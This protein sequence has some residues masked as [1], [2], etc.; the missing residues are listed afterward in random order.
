[1]NI[2]K[3]MGTGLFLATVATAFTPLA[4][5]A[6]DPE[7]EARIQAARE[8][9]DQAAADLG[10]AYAAVYAEDGVD[11]K[12]A[13]LGVLLDGEGDEN[14]VG[15][16]GV[17]PGGG[18]AA[19]G[20]TA[21]DTLI[22]I[23]DTSLLGL[24]NPGRTLGTELKA[25]APGDRVEVVY[26]RKGEEHT[27]TVETT[28]M[29][30]GAIAAMVQNMAPLVE[31]VGPAGQRRITIEH[32]APDLV[33]VQAEGDLAGYFGVGTGILV[34]HAPGSQDDLKAGDIVL[35][36]DGKAVDTVDALDRSLVESGKALELVVRRQGQEKAVTFLLGDRES[37]GTLRFQVMR[38]DQAPP[39]APE[40]ASGD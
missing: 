3:L 27:V 16:I 35:S 11:S 40:P 21:G 29:M 1:M 15:L 13:M 8:R 12:R 32:G 5:R 36:I 24:K 4:V 17:T 33:L 9:L 31:M 25:L 23:G 14:G 37:D 38:F 6:G 28:A 34:L 19:A 22:R 7:L 10:A 26:L 30:H 2:R 20:I 39:S 18:A